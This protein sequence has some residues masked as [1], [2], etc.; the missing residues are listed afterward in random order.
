MLTK[1]AIVHY[2]LVEEYD[3]CAEHDPCAVRPGLVSSP[4]LPS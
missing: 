3:R 2:V 1:V 4:I